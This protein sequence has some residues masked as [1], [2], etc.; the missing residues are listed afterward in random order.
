MLILLFSSSLRLVSQ[1]FSYESYYYKLQRNYALLKTNN[2]LEIKYQGNQKYLI[3]GK[4]TPN[5]EL[6]SILVTFN[7]EFD[8]AG[9]TIYEYQG[10][11][12]ILGLESSV[13]I[14]ASKSLSNFIK[15]KGCAKSSL[16]ELEKNGIKIF[17]WDYGY[18]EPLLKKTIEIYPKTNL[19]KKEKEELKRQKEIQEEI[20]RL[21]NEYF[22]ISEYDTIYREKLYTSIEN[23]AIRYFLDD[24]TP[25]IGEQKE[26]KSFFK[27]KL[28][29]KK[30]RDKSYGAR[31]NKVHE[32]KEIF[33]PKL[34]QNINI[35]LPELK[36]TFEGV[37]YKLNRFI[38]INLTY[39][40]IYGKVLVKKKK[41]GLKY[42]NEINSLTENQKSKIE[43]F[44]AKELSGNYKVSYQF[45]ILNNK[46][47]ARIICEK[48]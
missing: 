45:G 38:T 27:L 47:A 5:Q 34:L 20:H 14:E 4:L 32:Q 22:D 48:Y 24:I 30:N 36:E 9:K 8:F 23:T 25:N 18:K 3:K 40:I 43:H 10:L 44:M 11:G 35:S 26:V 7:K 2:G 21:E 42:K 16:S 39:D 13:V 6:L 28:Q 31:I 33:F 12:K 15:G 41:S 19:S 29:A 37:D 17:Y 1:S 46:D